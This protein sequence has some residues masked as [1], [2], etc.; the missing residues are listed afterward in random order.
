MKYKLASKTDV[1]LVRSN[2]EDYFLVNPE[3]NLFIVADGMGGYDKGEVASQMTCQG[4]LEFLAG[5]WD[6]IDAVHKNH[7]VEAVQYAN[8]M[9][10]KK[11]SE[12]K[13]LDRMGSTVVGMLAREDKLL[14][15]NVG[16][17]RAYRC[18]NGRLEQVSV[19]HS[20]VQETKNAGIKKELAPQFKNIVTRAMGMKDFVEVDVFSENALAGDSILLCSDGL[21]GFATDETIGSILLDTT[22]SVEQKVNMLVEE[23]KKNGGKD[24]I[25]AILIHFDEGN[26]EPKS[27]MTETYQI[28]AYKLEDANRMDGSHKW[29]FIF[30]LFL[31]VILMLV[32]FIYFL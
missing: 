21:H 27:S 22:L 14:F 25:T 19:D 12:S 29:A 7:V 6:K 18:R 8:R 4:I 30:L 13:D 5:Q 10:R 24:N 1:G 16:D 11:I 31:S 26:T 32:L 2:N 28:P 17:S 9:I 20:L 15:W 23:A 3:Y